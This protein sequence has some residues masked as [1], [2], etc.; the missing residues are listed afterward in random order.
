MHKFLLNEDQ[1][2]HSIEIW[3]HHDFPKTNKQFKYYFI[4]PFSRVFYFTI[5]LW[6]FSLLNTVFQ[7]SSSRVP[8]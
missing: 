3:I 5:I 4:I 7:G 1:S 2:S 8:D 6:Y